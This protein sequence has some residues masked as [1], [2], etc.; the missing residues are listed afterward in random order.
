MKAV[1]EWAATRNRED[2]FAQIGEGGWRPPHIRH[3]EFLDPADFKRILSSARLV[4]GHAGMGTILTALQSEKPV[5]VMPRRA[6][7]GEQRNEHQLATAREL[8]KK[9]GVEVANDADELM[10]KLDHMESLAAMAK[11]GPYADEQLQR[12][13]REFIRGEKPALAPEPTPVTQ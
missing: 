4:V 3:A 9:V 1:D 12:S 6:S 8:S 10:E 13:I 7:L 5:L 11:I 2:V